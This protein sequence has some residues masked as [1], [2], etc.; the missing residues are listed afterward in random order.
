[1]LLAAAAR[2]SGGEGRQGLEPEEVA[3]VVIIAVVDVLAASGC[4]RLVERELGAEV[5]E[6]QHVGEAEFVEGHLALLPGW[7]LRRRPVP[8]H[9]V[10]HLGATAGLH[11]RRAVQRR[12]AVQVTVTPLLFFHDQITVSHTHRLAWLSG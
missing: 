3:V 7:R 10:N 5:S 11:F 8:Q 6:L 4:G 9:V 1:M 2:S 12:K